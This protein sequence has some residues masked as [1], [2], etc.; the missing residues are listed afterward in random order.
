MRSTSQMSEAMKGAT[1]AMGMMNRG[2]NLPQ[3][4]KIMREFEK[5]S[6]VMEMKDEMMNDAVD[7]AMEG[8]DEGV[9]EEEAGDAI[10]KEVLDGI[11]VDLSQNVSAS[12]Q[13]SNVRGR[14]AKSFTV[15]DKWLSAHYICFLSLGH[16]HRFLFAARRSTI[17][18]TQR[19]PRSTTEGGHWRRDGVRRWQW[20]HPR[21]RRSRGSRFRAQVDGIIGRRRQRRR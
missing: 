12:V 6:E 16:G 4:M 17:R 7:E 2:M 11:G 15:D 5:E 3:V 13:E 14:T 9:G 8:D 10:L 20:E 18:I 1:K 21:F 19:S